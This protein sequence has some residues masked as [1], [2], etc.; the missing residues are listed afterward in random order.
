MV[1]PLK[2]CLSIIDWP[3]QFCQPVHHPTIPQCS[4]KSN[5]VA[6]WLPLFLSVQCQRWSVRWRKVS[7]FISVGVPKNMHSEIVSAIPVIFSPFFPL[8]S[9]YRGFLDVWNLKKK[10]TVFHVEVFHKIVK[11]KFEKNGLIKFDRWSVRWLKV[12]SSCISRQVHW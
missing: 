11:W 10:I 3:L 4:L 12:S 9:H 2:T 5:P 6:V 1:L 8:L 7:L